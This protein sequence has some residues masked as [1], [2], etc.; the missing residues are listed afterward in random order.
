L[1]DKAPLQTDIG[2]MADAVVQVYKTIAD[3]ER[4]LYPTFPVKEGRTIFPAVVTPENW[5]MFGPV[6]LKMLE[7]AVIGKARDAGFKPEW[8]KD[9]PYSVFA[10]EDLEAGL[11][12]LDSV[13]V[14]DFMDGKLQD[15]EMQ[16]WDWHAYMQAR[17]KKYFPVKKLFD[18]E[19]DQLTD[20]I[21]AATNKSATATGAIR[22][23]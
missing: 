11:Q 5:R 17:F 10:I 22:Q 13:G 14:T 15:R 1:T 16:Q 9:R 20:K 2:N 7:D 21:V 23:I 3:Y 6:M 8:V 12:I 19:Y 4:N 18:E